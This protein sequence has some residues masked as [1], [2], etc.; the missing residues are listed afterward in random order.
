[1]TA[2]E[3]ATLLAYIIAALFVVAIILMILALQQLRRG[4]K[5]PYWRI[6]RRA[7]QRGGILFL[8]SVGLLVIAGALLFYSG[9]AVIAFHDID[10]LFRRGSGGLIG[11]VVPT[12]TPTL[13]LTW[14]R[15]PTFDSHR[16]RQ[17]V[18][19]RHTIIHTDAN[20]NA[21]PQPDINR[22]RD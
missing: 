21:Q 7:S 15:T 4:R 14:T 19:N 22:H 5:G 3:I 12:E 18:A 11:V 17:P 20:A 6:R 1:M 9:L 8:A 2:R 13:N 16:D 10:S